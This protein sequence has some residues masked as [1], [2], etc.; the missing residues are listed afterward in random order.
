MYERKEWNIYLCIPP[1]GNIT[2]HPLMGIFTYT[3]HSPQVNERIELICIVMCTYQHVGVFVKGDGKPSKP[4]N[5]IK[6]RGTNMFTWDYRREFV[7]FILVAK[8]LLFPLPCLL[9]C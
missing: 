1:H 7:L 4:K 5:K 6:N 9:E 8:V 2:A 3:F